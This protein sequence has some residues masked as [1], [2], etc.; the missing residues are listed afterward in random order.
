[1][2]AHLLVSIVLVTP[3]VAS[4]K[5]AEKTA[6]NPPITVG[7]MTFS[8][9]RIKLEA[10]GTKEEHAFVCLIDG[11]AR[12]TF[13]TEGDV[14]LTIEADRIEVRTNVEGHSIVRAEGHCRFSDG[15]VGGS[16][17][18]LQLFDQQETPKTRAGVSAKG[19]G[20][21][22]ELRAEQKPTLTLTGDVTV[23]FGDPGKER[24]VKAASMS[25]VRGEWVAK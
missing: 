1:M 11:K 24:V 12:L 8:G 10:S 13:G 9:D 4:E 21:V 19:A 16:A 15:E 14:D 23:R 5:A 2:I 3:P 22:G 18:T 6:A 7:S 20:V 17:E 25:L